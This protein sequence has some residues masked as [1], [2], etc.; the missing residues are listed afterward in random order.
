MR[1]LYINWAPLWMGAEVGGGVNVYQQAMAIAMAE[2]GHEVYSL[3]SGYAYNLAGGVYLKRA[4]DYRDTINY[5]VVNTPNI[6]PGFFNYAFPNL[7]VEEMEVEAVFTRFLQEIQPDVV[8]FNN[9]EGFSAK[10]LPI[11]KSL[12]QKVLF[13]LHNYHPVCNQVY[14][15]Y[16]DK[17]ICT[18]FQ[19]GSRCLGC[20][21]PPPKQSEVRKRKFSYHFHLFPEGHILW[22]PILFLAKMLKTLKLSLK[23]IKSIFASRREKK[24]SHKQAIADLP[25]SDTTQ[26]PLSA[27]EKQHQGLPYQQRR[28]SMIEAINQADCVLAV[29]DWVKKVY[30]DMGIDVAKITTCHIGSKIASI[31]L[32]YKYIPQTKSPDEPLNIIFLG[33]CSLPKGLPF[34]LQTLL[35]MDNQVLGKMKLYIYARGIHELNGLL[36]PLS[37]RVA[38]L[39]TQDG[40]RYKDIPQI[41]KKMDVGIV[42][43]I[44]WDNAPQVVFEMLALNV[45]VIGANIGG[46]PDF[47]RHGENGLLFEPGDS[48]DLTTQL[49]TI[50]TRPTLVEKLKQGITPMK[51]IAEHAEELDKFYQPS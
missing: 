17:E 27:E 18:D 7:D 30:V 2:K 10:C 44:W 26:M 42:P 48:H 36:E 22:A 37:R 46:I 4:P 43:P 1:I 8:H 35:E 33:I 23:F 29:S 47:V 15:L 6:A 31:G 45:P 14:L 34:L 28:I 38:L 3:S 24:L 9:I 51:T 25:I 49:T 19:N 12:A 39:L 40:Y 50:I 41:L 21:A 20:I 5:E 16:Q 32:E 13:S 11:A